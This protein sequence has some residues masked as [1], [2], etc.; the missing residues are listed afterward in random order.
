MGV[1]GRG[2]FFALAPPAIILPQEELHEKAILLAYAILLVVFFAVARCL[3]RAQLPRPSTI[4]PRQLA[5]CGL[6][7]TR[8]ENATVVAQRRRLCW[9]SSGRHSTHCE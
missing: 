4:R 6:Q 3:R 8:V 7:H 9:D 5:P 1:Q 2:R